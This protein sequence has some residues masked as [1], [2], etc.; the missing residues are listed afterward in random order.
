MTHR[1]VRQ[2]LI[3]LSL[4]FAAAAPA[5]A[6]VVR[7]V[8]TDSNGQALPGVT[9]ELLA[10]TRSAVVTQTDEQ[11]RYTASVPA[12]TYDIIFRLIDFTSAASRDVSASD[13][14]ETVRDTTLQISAAASI[15]VTGKRTFRNLAEVDVPRNGIFRSADAASV[16]VITSKQLE[17]RP[18]RRAGDVLE[19]IP[20]VV[21]S[22][23]SGEGKA[24]QYYL[25]G[26]NLDHGTDFSTTVAGTPVNMPTSGHGQGYSDNSF[27]IPEL[28]SAIQYRKGPYYS[29][30]GDF[31]SAGT[32]NINYV[33]VLERPF[34]SFTGGGFGYRR[35][36]AA[37]STLF[38][39]GAILGA[40]E[41][42]TNDGPWIRPDEYQK[43]NGVL[44]YT[45][46]RKSYA[47]SVTAAAYEGR[48]NSTDQIPQ[49]AIRNGSLSLFG[50]VDPSDGGESH[51]YSLA[52]EWQRSGGTS[53]TKANSYFI[54]YGLK[55]FS[56][57]TYFL[58]DPINGDQFEQV[59]RRTVAGGRATHQWFQ[60]IFGRSAENMVGVELRRDDI[61]DVALYHTRER[62]RLD[63]IRADEVVQQSAGAFAQTSLQWSDRL[64]TVIGFRVDGYHFDVESIDAENSGSDDDRLVSPK[65]SVIFGPWRNT[66]MYASAGSGF[67]S[68]DARGVTL[69]RDPRSGDPARPVDA[70]VRTR[71]AEVG[72]RTTAMR[73]LQST[74]AVWRLD[75]D[76]ELLFSGDGGSTEPTRPSRRMGVEWS[77]YFHVSERLVLDADVAYS[78]GRFA[79]DDPAGDR[80]PGA[81]EGVVSAGVSVYDVGPFSGS[82]RYRYLGPRPLIEDDS[83]RSPAS[84]L[85]NATVAYALSSRYRVLVEALNLFNSRSSDIDY[86]YNSRLPGEPAGGIDDVHTHPLEPRAVRVRIQAM[87]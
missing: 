12:G 36:V 41:L 69:T 42:S 72:V 79:D 34:V 20:G 57:F 3:C 54:D 30:A 82:L 45:G 49:R 40:V 33:N 64:R 86:F 7:G 31:S 10:D 35:A 48:W 4:I 53:L 15:V 65:L 13:D 25:R 67:H 27:L 66:E 5:A 14:V 62:R 38:G 11:G 6:A 51:R 71:G 83:V 29:D 44:R 76:S 63:T 68:N 59:D 70:L 61:G 58:E 56:N 47:F 46:G 80:I 28:V 2:T 24:N 37:G 87:F 32:A 77:N 39:S 23:H 74:L 84:N 50:H 75:V 52:G 9:V 1:S 78:K 55:L 16:G 73:R 21:V 18:I 60:T 81:V 17:A 22:Q 19:T 26:F 85:V 43:L 8:V